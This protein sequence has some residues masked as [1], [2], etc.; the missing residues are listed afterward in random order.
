MCF[1]WDP[2]S[3]G[4]SKRPQGAQ[5]LFSSLQG[6]GQR[7]PLGAQPSDA[8]MRSAMVTLLQLVGEHTAV[9]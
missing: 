5:P 2:V 3:K 8:A 4:E 1:S 9:S 7:E 6:W